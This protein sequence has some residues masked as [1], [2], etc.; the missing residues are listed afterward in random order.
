MKRPVGI[1]QARHDGELR[2]AFDRVERS[3]RNGISSFQDSLSSF[4]RETGLT[5]RRVVPPVY[6]A[7]DAAAGPDLARRARPMR[8]SKGVLTVEVDSAGHLHELQT[9]RGEELRQRVNEILGKPDV[10]RIA[11][12]PKN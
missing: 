8:M 2:A 1:D 5:R 9:F 12:K 6:T 3:G 10:R 4:L 7:F 11:F